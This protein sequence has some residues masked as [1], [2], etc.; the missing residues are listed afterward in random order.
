M[1]KEPGE[2]SYF[3]TMEK[4]KLPKPGTHQRWVGKWRKQRKKKTTR[5][6]FRTMPNVNYV[7]KNKSFSKGKVWGCASK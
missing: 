2:F 1:R 4:C 5:K 3:L 7:S 6:C